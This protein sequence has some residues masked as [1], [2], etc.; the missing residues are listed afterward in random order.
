[1]FT[2]IYRNLFIIY[3]K[4]LSEKVKFPT[5]FLS[6]QNPAYIYTA[7]LGN[8]EELLDLNAYN[9][10][11]IFYAQTIYHNHYGAL[12]HANSLHHNQVFLISKLKQ[13]HL[14]NW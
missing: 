14:L 2:S 8:I 10:Y 1:M 9:I 11:W 3:Q 5:K 13:G 12:L 6:D 7:F 4:S